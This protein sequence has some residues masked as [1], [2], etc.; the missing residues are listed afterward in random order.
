M[1]SKMTN[2]E[3]HSATKE[4]LMTVTTSS[5]KP[6]APMR[7]LIAE[8][9]IRDNDKITIYLKCAYHLAKRELPKSK[10][11]AMLDLIDMLGCDIKTEGHA[12]YT[13]HQRITEFQSALAT[14]ILQE[15][16]EDI[17]QSVF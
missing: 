10:F 9:V 1:P 5:L 14:T 3:R 2:H 4:H 17:K 11:S 8:K 15:K 12:T 16:L 7:K 13:S 6:Q